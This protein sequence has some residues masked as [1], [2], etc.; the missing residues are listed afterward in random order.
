MRRKACVAS[1]VPG[2]RA[3]A[4]QLLAGLREE[5]GRFVEEYRQYLTV[6]VVVNFEQRCVIGA[7]VG[8]VAAGDGGGDGVRLL[9][10]D[11]ACSIGSALRSPGLAAAVGSPTAASSRL[12]VLPC[13]SSSA[14]RAATASLSSIPR[15]GTVSWRKRFQLVDDLGRL[16]LVAGAERFTRANAR[17][18]CAQACDGASEYRLRRARQRRAA[19]L[20]AEQAHLQ[21]LGGGGDQRKPAGAMNPA[22]RVA[23]AH[24]QLRRR[25]RRVELQ[26]LQLVIQRGQMLLGLF[27]QR[28]DTAPPKA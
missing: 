25:R 28:C 12:I 5:F 9:G 17:A 3:P 7:G 2:L 21:R 27:T 10:A 24:H 22:Q 4:A 8:A 19:F 26:R 14:T 18:Q 1:R 15:C 13:S 6:D 20:Q 11:T 23:G 16:G